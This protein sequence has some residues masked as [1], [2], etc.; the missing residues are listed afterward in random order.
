MPNLTVL[1]G[2]VPI[3]Q[4]GCLSDH[5]IAGENT[6]LCNVGIFRRDTKEFTE[7]LIGIMLS[8]IRGQKV[9]CEF[10]ALLGQNAPVWQS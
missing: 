4:F 2:P 6:E 3:E 1:F 7:P 8:H 9:Q 10:R 5:K